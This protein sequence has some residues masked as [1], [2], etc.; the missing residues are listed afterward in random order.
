VILTSLFP[1]RLKNMQKIYNELFPTDGILEYKNDEEFYQKL[2]E[3]HQMSY[4]V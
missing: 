2:L 3:I 1:N 4:M